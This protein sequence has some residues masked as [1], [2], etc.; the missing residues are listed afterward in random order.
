M[1]NILIISFSPIK[2]DP[3]V[4]R[5]ID[6]LK[7]TYNLTVVGLGDSPYPDINFHSCSILRS[8]LLKKTYE[9]LL[10]IC[11]RF[12]FFYWKSAYISLAN[13]YLQKKKFD[14]IISNDITSLPLALQIADGAP[15]L[16][17][18]H[19]YS[20]KEFE[21]RLI[22][23]LL[24][25]KYNEY[26]CRKYLPK[27]SV[28]T[29]V[30]A[31]IAEQYEHEF[32][33]KSTVVLNAPR[34]ENLLPSPLSGNA[35]RLIH[36]GLATSSR[37]LEIMIDMMDLLDDRFRLDL[38]LVDNGTGY[39][40]ILKER[41]KSNP[42]IRFRQ[43]V[44]M[45]KIAAEINEYDI[46]I[47]ILPPV[48]FNYRYALPNKFFEFIQARLAVAIGPSEE[49]A[50][51]TRK[52]N[53]GIVVDDFLPETMAR[54]LSRLSADQITAM[55]E[56]SNKAAVSLNADTSQKALLDTI[57]TLLIAPKKC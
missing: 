11:K 45:K 33:V 30:C 18:A 36:H 44:E 23:R 42:R 8:S 19:E 29:T 54:A 20:P 57:E 26:L 6:A 32:G 2:S 14:F 15:V 17:D 4:M 46:G 37:K 53:F 1:K 47:F 9:S 10:L 22:W 3:R 31:G 55:K 39:L 52:Y 25:M 28:M 7:G 12:D 51:L 48:N 49:M 27:A 50:R 24:H 21:D 16:H 38:M 13:A 56:A 35:V 40:A 34:Y 43:P 5:Q 41:A